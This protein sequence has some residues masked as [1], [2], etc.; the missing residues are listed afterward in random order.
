MELPKHMPVD[1]RRM[2]S[3][4]LRCDGAL[5]VS[6]SGRNALIICAS[7]LA[8]AVL[9]FARSVFAPVAVSLF[10]VAVVW[11]LQKWLEERLPQ[12]VALAI[13][14][15]L[16]AVAL[17]ALLALS[18]WGIGQVGRWTIA[19][20]AHLQAFYVQITQ[21]LESHGIFVV[22]IFLERFDLLWLVRP[23]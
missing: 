20:A 7:V 6:G 19:N 13:T 18:I 15:L 5:I 21:W 9:H 12:L 10:A 8:L 1:S 14:L 16:T 22:G 3:V 4:R 11:P 2:R 23:A 17:S